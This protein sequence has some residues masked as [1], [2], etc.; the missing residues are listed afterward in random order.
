MRHNVRLW[1]YKCNAR[2]RPHQRYA[3]DWRVFFD[4]PAD[5]RWGGTRGNYDQPLSFPHEQHPSNH[6]E[7]PT[8]PVG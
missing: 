5:G 1:V 4:A 2:S 8:E 7:Q 3:G 6:A